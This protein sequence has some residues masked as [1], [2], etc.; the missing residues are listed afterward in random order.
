MI[1]IK[2]FLLV[3]FNLVFKYLVAWPLTPFIVLFAKSDGWLPGWLSWFQTN[4]NSLDGDDGWKS[5]TRPF[6]NNDRRFYRYL[7]RCFWLWRN[8]LYGFNESV[9]SV[10]FCTGLDKICE[11]L[12]IK[13]HP[14]VSNGP[15]GKS[16]TVWRYYYLN[17]K[18]KAWQYYYIRR[19]KRWPGRCIRINLGW[20]LFSYGGSSKTA[21]A[22]LSCWV[23]RFTP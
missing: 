16:G 3:T 23:N 10:K 5:G 2:W 11:I 21:H 15:K 12:V 6:K 13:G 8:S 17:G 1:Y 4:D 22:A 20:K 18:L 14:G 7:N 9:L 19:L